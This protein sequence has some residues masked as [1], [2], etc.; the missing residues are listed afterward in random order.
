MSREEIIARNLMT[1]ADFDACASYALQLFALGQDVADQHG[2][3]LVDTKYEFGRDSQGT[4]C[5]I[6]EIHTP[7]SSRYWLSTSYEER[8]ANDQ[9]PENVDKEILRR[10]FD[11]HC[12]PYKDA[13]LPSAPQELVVELSRRYIQLYEMITWK[14]FEF[15][16]MQSPADIVQSI[17]PWL[18]PANHHRS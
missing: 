2:L 12:D 3:I 16:T 15:D 4:I 6:D 14:K 11:E 8:L 7:D 9:E 18:S 17:S 1:A 10:W 5:L 13:K